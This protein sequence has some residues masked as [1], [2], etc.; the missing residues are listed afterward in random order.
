MDLY[1]V[2]NELNIKYDEISHKALYTIEDALNEN[3]TSKINGIEC[4]NLFV[5]YK[6]NY[7]LIFMDSNKKANLKSIARL[8]NVQKLSF[9]SFQEL[10]EILGLEIGSVTPMGIINDKNNL[11]T[12]LLDKNLKNKNVL[13]HPIVNTKTISIKFEDLIKFI[14]YLNHKYIMEE[15]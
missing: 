11:V 3:I 4:K 14:K 10:K 13:V 2:L 8:L 9:A 12:L 15:L 7:Y 6:N 1:E 5:K